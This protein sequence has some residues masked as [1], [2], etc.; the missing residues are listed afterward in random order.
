MRAY[1]HG[2]GWGTP[3]TSQRNILIRKNSHKCFLCSGRDSNLWSW[4][5]L[6][7]ISRPTLYQLSHHV[8][9]NQS[10]LG[11]RGQHLGG[12]RYPIYQVRLEPS[13]AIDRQTRR[14]SNALESGHGRLRQK[15][16]KVGKAHPNLHEFID[17]LKE[18]Q[19]DT[20]VR[21]WVHLNAGAIILIMKG[22]RS[23]WY[24]LSSALGIGSREQLTPRW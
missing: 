3:I 10:V 19:Q 15:A 9:V 17:P 22:T 20:D 2:R 18:E 11:L 4:N 5:P 6:A 16:G 21:E 23:S 12:H 24:A 1:T 14:T 13:H 7:R 8:P